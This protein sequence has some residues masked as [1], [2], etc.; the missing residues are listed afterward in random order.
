MFRRIAALGALIALPGLASAECFTASS[1]TFCNDDTVFSGAPNVSDNPNAVMFE[2]GPYFANAIEIVGDDI[3]ELDLAEIL[4]FVIATAAENGGM[5]IDN[6]MANREVL[7]TDELNG[8][9]FA[10]E[11]GASSLGFGVDVTSVAKTPTGYIAVTT[12]DLQGT[13]LTGELIGAHLDLLKA[14]RIGGG[15][16]PAPTPAP[17][18]GCDSFGGGVTFCGASAGLPTTGS[19]YDGTTAA[20]DVGPIEFE[21][22]TVVLDGGGVSLADYRDY[23]VN[24]LM[25]QASGQPAPMEP[26]TETEVVLGT[27]TPGLLMAYGDGTEPYEMLIIGAFDGGVILITSREPGSLE[28][29]DTHIDVLVNAMAGLSFP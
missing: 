11:G 28:F 24:T 21:M 16:A 10:S 23:V 15:S 2:S 18:G 8:V 3:N 17:A 19:T 20:Y 14:A 27:G 13:E 7:G 12:I 22:S 5:T 29:T 25:P 26:A 9:E 4:F 1:V 6:Y